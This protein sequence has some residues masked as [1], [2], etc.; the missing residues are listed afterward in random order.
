MRQRGQT[1]TFQ[2]RLEISENAAAGLNDTQLATALGCSVWT[3]RK[4]RR[5]SQQLG[6]VG[7]VSHR[8]RPATGPV[9]TF[10]NQLKEAILHLRKLHPG[11]G[12]NTLLVALK[13]DAAFGD[14]LL[15]SRDKSPGCSSKQA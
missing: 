1:T 11:W 14:Q 10:P 6:R 8:G 9:S 13:T 5:R 2:M 3:V 12:P 7:L 4:W 15:P